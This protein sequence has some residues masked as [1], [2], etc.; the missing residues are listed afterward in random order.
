MCLARSFRLW[1]QESRLFLSRSESTHGHKCAGNKRHKRPVCPEEAELILE[2]LLHP[3]ALPSGG[4]QHSSAGTIHPL[5]LRRLCLHSSSDARNIFLSHPH[6]SV[7]SRCASIQPVFKYLPSTSFHHAHT[8]FFVIHPLPSSVMMMRTF[9]LFCHRPFCF[10]PYCAHFFL[11]WSCCNC[12]QR[13]NIAT[14]ADVACGAR[15]V[16]AFPF[17]AAQETRPHL[18]V[19]RSHSCK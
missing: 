1:T 16:I 6:L 12:L 11:C 9:S 8:H 17:A 18:Q 7:A 10:F 4:R 3:K 2:R 15:V 14:K 5:R 19:R 13:T